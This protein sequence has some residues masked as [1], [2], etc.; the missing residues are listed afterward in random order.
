MPYP[1]TYQK[2]FPGGKEYSG[3][4]EKTLMTKEKK[5]RKL[6]KCFCKDILKKETIIIRQIRTLK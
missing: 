4:F 3:K 5:Q 6:G 1:K 2:I